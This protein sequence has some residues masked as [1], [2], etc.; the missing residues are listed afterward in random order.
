MR[1]FHRGLVVGKFSPLHHGHELLIR[2]AM[3]RCNEVVV[4]SYSKP[5]FSGCEADRR[6]KWLDELFPTAR[7]LVVTDESL[8]GFDDFHLKKM[9]DNGDA[10]TIHRR[11]VASL[12]T[13]VLG[14]T[15]D[16]VFT[17][18]EYGDAFA[19]ELSEYFREDSGSSGAVRHEPVDPGRHEV[20][21]SGTQLRS[22]IHAN[23]R[24]LSPIVYASFIKRICILGGESSGKSTLTAALAER[25]QT[26]HV[27]EYGRDLWEQNGGVLAL[28]DMLP[29]ARTQVVRE[30]EA[31]LHAHRYLF[32]DTSP[33]TTLFYSRR[34][35]GYADPALERMAERRYDLVVLCAPDF[36]F[37]QDGTRQPDSFREEQHGWYLEELRVRRVPYLLVTGDLENRVMQVAS[38]LRKNAPFPKS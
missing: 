7:A 10:E 21:I 18:E 38:H 17:S 9:P 34:L 13:R 8:H 27:A 11:F 26:T 19:A 25:F 4:I 28:S 1:N 2:H 30:E 23:R 33:L 16:A 12:C 14:V 24:F 29:I 5:E 20:S 32:C 3:D 6:K 22:D 37:V 15:V 31:C 35:F 36:P